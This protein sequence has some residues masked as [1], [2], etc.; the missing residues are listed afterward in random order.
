MLSTA[1]SVGTQTCLDLEE[2]NNY[3]HDGARL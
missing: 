1:V 2:V 3:F